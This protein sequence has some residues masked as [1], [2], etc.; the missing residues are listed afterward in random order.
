MNKPKFRAWDKINQKMYQVSSIHIEDEYMYL[1]DKN[2]YEGEFTRKN[3]DVILMQYTGLKDDSEEQFEI[4]E[5]SIV[6]VVDNQG[7]YF[8]GV[9]EYFADENYPAFDIH[10]KYYKG[11]YFESNVLSE[12]KQNDTLSIYVI[13][14]IYTTPEL[15]SGVE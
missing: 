11:W 2:I 7:D 8:I 14:D 3:E 10:A 12:A 1:F 15:L 4:Y 5:K 6:K 9:V 13:G